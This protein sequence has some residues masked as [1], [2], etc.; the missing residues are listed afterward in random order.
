MI[1]RYSMKNEMLWCGPAKYFWV[2]VIPTVQCLVTPQPTRLHLCGLIGQNLSGWHLFLT[3]S[4][5]C[6]LQYLCLSVRTQDQRNN[7]T[8]THLLS[9]P[10]W[11]PTLSR[12]S[13][14]SNT[15]VWP[16]NSRSLNSSTF[17]LH[18]IAKEIVKYV[19]SP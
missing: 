12:L 8:L 6:P 18:E 2:S 15:S 13:L 11:H 10:G 14:C 9:W 1:H 7:L 19:N 17:V 4:Y 3:I 16:F 5:Q